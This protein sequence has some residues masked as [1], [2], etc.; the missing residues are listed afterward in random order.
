MAEHR[1]WPHDVPVEHD[2]ATHPTYRPAPT[3]TTVR[4]PTDADL[5]R[6][7]ALYERVAVR[8]RHGTTGQGALRTEDDLRRTWEARHDDALVVVRTEGAELED[9]DGEDD[10]D[11]LVVGY[12][13]FHEDV[14]PWTPALDLY[15]EGR[16]DPRVDARTVAE[17]LFGRALDRAH[18]AARRHPDLPT[19]LRTTVVDPSPATIRWFEEHGLV[20]ERHLLRLRI[21]VGAGTPAPDWPAGV[22]GVPAD[23]LPDDEVHAALVAAFADHHLGATDDLDDWRAVRLRTGRVDLAASLAAVTDDGQ[24][25][26]VSLGRLEG[27]RDPGAGLVTDLGV[28]PAWRGRGVATALLRAS[29]R[30]FA[31]LGAVHVALGVDDVTLDGALRLY[32][33]A[34]MEVVHHAIVLTT[35]PL[36]A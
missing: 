10:E 26:G 18:R 4:R 14:D 28:V 9:V 20:P 17:F 27:P 22:H 1:A 30:R 32:E 5:P 2:E 15:A 13:E 29:F 24:V 7:A 21:D 34:G 3:G 35:G 19:S 8:S 6:I 23:A 36:D 12:L 16:V 31:A 25:V 33:R 11:Q